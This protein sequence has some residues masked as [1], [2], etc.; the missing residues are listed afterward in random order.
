LRSFAS[1][2]FAPL[3]VFSI[4]YS[5]K[6]DSG[7]DGDGTQEVLTSWPAASKT[8]AQQMIAKYGQPQG[9]GGEMLTW[10]SKGPWRR[11]VVHRDGI[12]HNFPTPHFDFLQQTIDYK[13]PIDKYV[14]LATYNGSIVVERTNGELSSR[15]DLEATNFLSVNLANDI[16]T[17]V[18][19]AQEA[20]TY[21]AQA[22]RNFLQSGQVDPY[23]QVLRFG[24][25]SGGT[26]DPD[27]RVF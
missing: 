23:M 13:A 15:C 6:K 2:A 24:V 8:I 16:A 4:L 18:R 9:I 11:T 1:L 12:P 17:G 27:A 25:A 7:N 19:T 3:F 10:Q 14:D 5:C 22:I 21:H 26:K 20:R